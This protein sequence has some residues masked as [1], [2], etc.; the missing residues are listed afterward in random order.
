MSGSKKIEPPIR[1]CKSRRC[2]HNIP[3]GANDAGGGSGFK[4][5]AAGKAIQQRCCLTPH[6]ETK[7]TSPMEVVLLAGDGR[8]TDLNTEPPPT[9]YFQNQKRAG[10]W[11]IPW[12]LPLDSEF[13]FLIILPGMFSSHIIKLVENLR[14]YIDQPFCQ[15]I[16]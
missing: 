15:L 13:L 4:Y 9:T 16:T 7:V 6:C 5:S 10:T 14:D 3:G 12:C 1:V 2:S 8:Q 11:S